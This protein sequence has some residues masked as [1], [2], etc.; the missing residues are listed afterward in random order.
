MAPQTTAGIDESEDGG[1]DHGVAG[2]HEHSGFL[3]ETGGSAVRRELQADA[4]AR[5]ATVAPA[6]K[7]NASRTGFGTTI[8]ST[9]SMVASL[10][11]TANRRRISG[12]SAK[13]A[14][15]QFTMYHLL[16]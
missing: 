11:N 10:G 2:R 15:H 13:G 9:P 12:F 4:V 16:M 1:V 3:N 8:R 14:S 6:A 5:D 7:P